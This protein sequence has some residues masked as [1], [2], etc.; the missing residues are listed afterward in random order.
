MDATKFYT[1]EKFELFIGDGK[2]HGSGLRLDNSKGGVNLKIQRKGTGSGSVNCH[3]FV[4]A[5]AQFDI[6][7]NNI[8]YVMY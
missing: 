1:E 4:L 5:D 6:L 2:M 8:E 7:N 3:I